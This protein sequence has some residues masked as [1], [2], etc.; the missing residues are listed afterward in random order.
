MVPL[1]LVEDIVC[2][3]QRCR[4]ARDWSQLLRL[5]VHLHKCGLETHIVVGNH[6]VQML[7]EAGSM[8]DAHQVFDM[9][10]YR[11]EHTWTSLIAGYVKCGNPQHALKVYEDMQKD[12]YVH[13][14]G[15]TFVALLKACTKLKD[16]ER[17]LQVHSKID[18]LGMSQGDVFIGSA[19]VDMYVK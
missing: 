9:L 4:K 2:T 18:E 11:S 19:L 17:G 14:S 16:L 1:H 7:V 13:P 10:V 5:H 8:Y 12:S 15:H 6:L 3:L